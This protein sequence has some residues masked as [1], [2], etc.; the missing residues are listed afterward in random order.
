MASNLFLA[1]GARGSSFLRSL[2]LTGVIV[3]FTATRF[4]VAKEDSTSLSLVSACS[5]QQIKL[6]NKQKRD[7]LCGKQTMLPELS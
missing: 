7:G 4:L 5:N 6:R 1:G 3:K 2:A